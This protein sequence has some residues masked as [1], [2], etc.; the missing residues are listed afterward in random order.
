VVE[1][2]EGWAEAIEKTITDA[3]SQDYNFWRRGH[4]GA[5]ARFK[6]TRDI[7]LLVEGK[8]V[9][10]IKPLT[11][12]KWE[13]L[14]DDQLRSHADG[15]L[16]DDFGGLRAPRLGFRERIRR[17]GFPRWV[18]PP[19]LGGAKS[20]VDNSTIHKVCNYRAARLP[21]AKD[22]DLAEL[23]EEALRGQAVLAD[24][25]AVL[26]QRANFFLGAAG[27]TSSLVL[28]NS[29]LLL[30]T[31]KLS[32]PWLGMAIVFLA[33]SSVCA[34]LA[35]FRAMQAAMTTFIRAT[36]SNSHGISERAELSG[37]HL[38]RSYVGALLVA[39]NREEVVGSWKLARLKSARRWFLATIVGISLLTGVVLL[40][41][42]DTPTASTPAAQSHH[43]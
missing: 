40:D 6:S 35:G 27:L 23:K 39:Q 28:A 26:E 36:P 17:L 13:R 11:F 33:V 30:G 24:R 38:A 22:A 19:L 9:L 14:S 37:P 5:L 7:E 41:V 3:R 18:F 20:K 4:D 42:V 2:S 43:G 16:I 1:R 12:H 31:A 32:D 15:F 34:V 8:W 29:G 25:C 21:L 10:I